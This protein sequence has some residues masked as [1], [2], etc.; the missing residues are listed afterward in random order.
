MNSSKTSRSA[1]I[2]LLQV[3]VWENRRFMLA[4]G[5][6]IEIGK[7]IRLAVNDDDQLLDDGGPDGFA[8]EKSAAVTRGRFE[9]LASTL[10]TPRLN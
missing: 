9:L 7:G 2:D 10:K 4:L 5:I 6:G 3:A 1:A 8:V